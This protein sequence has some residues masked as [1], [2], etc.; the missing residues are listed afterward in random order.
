MRKLI[1]FYSVFLAC[2][3]IL[4]VIFGASGCY[5]KKKKP[6]ESTTPEGIAQESKPVTVYG[7]QTSAVVKAKPDEMVKH[8]LKDF[9]W[10]KTASKTIK[11]KIVDLRPDT[12]MTQLGQS[13]GL[14][15]RVLGINFPCQ[16]VTLRYKPEKEFWCIILT[17]GSWILVRAKVSAIPEG[18]ML[19]WNLIGMPSKS[20]GSVA[21]TLQLS[22]TLPGVIDQFIAS[23]QS[24]FD[25]K[26]NIQEVTEKG[27]RGEPFEKFLQSH[28]ARVRV[29]APPEKVEA[30]V[31]DPKYIPIYLKEINVEESSLVQFQQAPKDAI[32]YAPAVLDIGFLRPKADV[33]NIKKEREGGKGFITRM[34][35]TI[36]NMIS[37]SELEIQPDAGGSLLRMKMI[38]EI[39][40][41]I[42][43]DMMEVMLFSTGIP[44][45]LQEKVMIIKEGVE[46]KD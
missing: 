39:P 30:W 6:S 13:L 7:Y 2:V 15:I 41:N 25:P 18:S 34:Y 4:F 37:V 9:S 45:L 32:V 21:D 23:I 27:L 35:L 42:S 14:N 20:M 5:P 3:L 12:D 29:N 1:T 46:Q 40:T 11:F 33:F 10:L 36:Y 16:F 24:E 43:S 28:E 8:I 22:K 44:K 31:T 19:E 17:G 38:F 26:I